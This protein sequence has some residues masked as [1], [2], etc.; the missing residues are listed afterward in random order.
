MGPS[1]QLMT[2]SGGWHSFLAFSSEKA[3]AHKPRPCKHFHS[4]AGDGI[5]T[6]DVQLGKQNH[7]VGRNQWKSLLGNT[8]API[9]T[10]RKFRVLS[11]Q[12]ARVRIF[13]TRKAVRV[14]D[15]KWH[16]R[17]GANGSAR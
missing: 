17:R 14:C 11:H 15:V 16:R 3:Q 12:F 13:R 1:D 9:R 10:F 4:K 2:N 8:L 6:H 5:R 7:L